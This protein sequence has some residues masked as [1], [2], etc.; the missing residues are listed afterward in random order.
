MIT[1]PKRWIMVNSVRIV[2]LPLSCSLLFPEMLKAPPSVGNS[3]GNGWGAAAAAST[4]MGWGTKDTA[5]SPAE[6][7][8]SEGMAICDD[9]YSKANNQNKI[10]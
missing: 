6:S 4:S 8:V 10:M 9:R 7:Q 5:T 1:E 2:R 3:A